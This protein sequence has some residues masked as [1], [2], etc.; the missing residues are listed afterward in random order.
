LNKNTTG[1]FDYLSTST[2]KPPLLGSGY[3]VVVYITDCGHSSMPPKT[4]LTA[5]YTAIMLL[6]K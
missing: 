4:Y 6:I 2:I 1:C 5:G 3:K